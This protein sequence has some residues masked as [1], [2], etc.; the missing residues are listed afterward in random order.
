MLIAKEFQGLVLGMTLAAGVVG[1]I[2]PGI[3]R[4][5]VDIWHPDGSLEKQWHTISTSAAKLLTRQQAR[6]SG[7]SP[8]P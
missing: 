1:E 7:S 4:F 6:S 8:P 5:V 3:D 2:Y